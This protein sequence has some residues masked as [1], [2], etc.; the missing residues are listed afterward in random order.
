MMQAEV[1][2]EPG[3][4]SRTGGGGPV[5]LGGGG[6]PGVKPEAGVELATSLTKVSKAAAAPN[7]RIEPDNFWDNK[8]FISS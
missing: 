4:G 2:V 5:D 7:P 3:S 1:G 6:H 8:C